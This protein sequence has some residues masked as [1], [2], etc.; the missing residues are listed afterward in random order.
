MPNAVGRSVRTLL[1]VLVLRGWLFGV[2][3][4]VMSSRIMAS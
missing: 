1:S 2:A 4:A 3:G